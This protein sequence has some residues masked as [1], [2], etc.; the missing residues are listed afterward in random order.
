MHR[1]ADAAEA[2]DASARWWV[3]GLVGWWLVVDRWWL[4]VAAAWGAGGL[5]GWWVGAWWLV[6]EWVAGLVCWLVVDG[7]CCQVGRCV[8]VLVG[9]RWWLLPGGQGCW[10][11]GWWLVLVAAWW[12]GG[13]VG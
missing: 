7:G 9:G 5:V 10:W 1:L 8:G 3:S 2:R 12:V 4:V 11:V 6:S 13:L